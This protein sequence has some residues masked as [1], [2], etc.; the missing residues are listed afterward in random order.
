MSSQESCC[1]TTDHGSMAPMTIADKDRIFVHVSELQYI[2]HNMY[3]FL[4]SF[5]IGVIWPCEFM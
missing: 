3:M 2:L 4:A 5:F 1:I